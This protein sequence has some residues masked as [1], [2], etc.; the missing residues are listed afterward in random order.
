MRQVE[1]RDVTREAIAARD[2]DERRINAYVEGAIDRF[3]GFRIPVLGPKR[4][5]EARLAMQNFSRNPGTNM[6]ENMK[7]GTDTYK[8][9]HFEKAR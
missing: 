1:V 8:V 6:Y 4:R 7:N 3:V 5:V 9:V 2:Q